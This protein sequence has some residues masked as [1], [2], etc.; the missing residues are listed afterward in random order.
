LVAE[1]TQNTTSTLSTSRVLLHSAAIVISA[2]TTAPDT[3]F[4]SGPANDA[5]LTGNTGT[6]GLASTESP[7]T[8]ECKIDQGSYSSCAASYTTPALSDGKHVIK[9]R[10]T[11]AAG[12]TDESS[13]ARTVWVVTPLG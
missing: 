12:N 7:S 13:A 8:F 6:F 5:V 11:D 1:W 2:D 3:S 4:S 9:V 10:A